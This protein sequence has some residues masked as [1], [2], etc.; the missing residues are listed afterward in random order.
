ML[1]AVDIGN[2][3]IKAA[4]FEDN[5][6]VE[7]FSFPQEEAV[8]Q[9]A[10]ILKKYPRA[11]KSILSSVGKEQ[12][13]LLLW[14]KN[15]TLFTGINH[16]SVFPFTNK[17][18]TPATLG[19]DRMVLA[20]GAVLQHPGKNRLVI[21]AGTCITYDFVSGADDYLGGAISP[22][23]QLRY[24]AMHTFTAK[25]PLLYPEMPQSFT[26]N[27]TAQSM[28]VGA[29]NGLLHEIDGFVQ[30]Y[31]EQY[32]DVTVILTGGDADFL[33]KRLKN[34]IFANSNFLLE[35]LNHLYHY[36]NRND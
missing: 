18:A 4:V 35:S 36:T 7:K 34:T 11:T 33:A 13:E 15:N 5:A 22:G 32:Q 25:L 16:T 14:L 10:E 23:L 3:K 20:A 27:S 17:Y 28:H 21:D 9:V 31:V 26:G 1:L 19:I 12:N 29:V 2:T 6:L 8:T 24:N 30:Q